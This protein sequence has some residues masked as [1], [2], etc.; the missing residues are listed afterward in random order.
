MTIAAI[1]SPPHIPGPTLRLAGLDPER[2]YRVARVRIDG[3]DDP[4]STRAQ[5]AW[6]HEEFTCPGSVLM[7]IGLP[8]PTLRPQEA[9]LIEVV[10]QR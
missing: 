7:Q 1:D 4:T 2:L 8:M 5:P 3:A 10:G 9:A 6:W